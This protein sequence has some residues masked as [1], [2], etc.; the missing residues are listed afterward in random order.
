LLE[1]NSA[2]PNNLSGIVTDRAGTDVP[3]A[4]TTA[5]NRQTGVSVQIVSQV[6][7]AYVIPKVE[8]G[9]YN[10]SV[11]KSGLQTKVLTG[12][13]LQVPQQVT[14][15]IGMELGQVTASVEAGAQAPIVQVS[16]VSVGTVIDSQRGIDLPLNTLY[17][18][19]VAV[20]VPGTTIDRGGFAGAELSSP[21]A[22]TAYSADP[23]RSSD[24]NILIDSLMARA[25]TGG[26]FSI[27]PTPD[28]VQEFKIE[29]VTYDT[30]LGMSSGSVIN[31]SQ[32][33]GQM[34]GMGRRP[35]FCETT[36]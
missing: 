5:A 13:T 8:P 11:E 24:N 6:S 34:T 1:V 2:L 25:L 31:L 33:R 18:G 23:S 21:F 12:V 15:E 7:G 35:S 26:G 4:K 29:T 17:F 20:L 30:S 3:D 36:R 28:G 16:T 22:G 19:A 9:T 32:S 10:I 27:Q 14:L